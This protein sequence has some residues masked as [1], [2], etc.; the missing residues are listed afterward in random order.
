VVEVA[1]RPGLPCGGGGVSGGARVGR[2][3]LLDRS[4]TVRGGVY[5]GALPRLLGG[6]S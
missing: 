6:P 1:A 5:G 4:V 3:G 2:V